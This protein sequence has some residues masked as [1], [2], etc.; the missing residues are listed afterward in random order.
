MQPAPNLLKRKLTE[1]GGDPL[2]CPEWSSLFNDIIHNAPIDDNPKMCH[3]NTLVNDKTKGARAGSGYS[4]VLYHRAWENLVRNLGRSHS[5]V[6][7]Q[8]KQFH[9][10]PFINSENSTARIRYSQLISVF[11]NLLNQYGFTGDLCFES[12]LSSAIR[13]LSLELRTR[14]LF[15]AKGRSHLLDS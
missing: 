9:L 11:V 3:L 7:A 1:V 10:F 14:W 8:I 6:N 12:V 2:E 4:G 15:Y 13:K 5:L